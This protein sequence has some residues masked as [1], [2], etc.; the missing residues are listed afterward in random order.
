MAE[1]G[2]R[3]APAG[4]PASRRRQGWSASWGRQIVGGLAGAV[5]GWGAVQVGPLVGWR[6]TDPALPILWGAALGAA[7]TSLGGFVAAGSRLT[8][9]QGRQA[10]WINLLAAL[11]AVIVLF[12]LAAGTLALVGA[13]LK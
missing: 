7:L 3:T 11:L 2:R 8:G 1:Q 6:P 10:L 5:L 12:A 4:E 9:R 13:L